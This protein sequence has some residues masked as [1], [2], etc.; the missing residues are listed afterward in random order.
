[1]RSKAKTHNMG[2]VI[3]RLTFGHFGGGGDFITKEALK[4]L[5]LMID[6]I[7]SQ[8]TVA[9]VPRLWPHLKKYN[10]LILM[11]HS[12]GLSKYWEWKMTAKY[13]NINEQL[14]LDLSKQNTYDIGPKKLNLKNFAGLLTLW[15]VGMF[16]SLLVFVGELLCFKWRK[17]NLKK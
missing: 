2:F 15:I 14:Q 1:M 4:R 7:F 8:Y 10:E 16:L 12:S 17:R 9:M 6:E 5:K 3:E 13:L 11:W